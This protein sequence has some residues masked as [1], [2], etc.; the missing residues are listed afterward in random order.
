MQFSEKDQE[1]INL[2]LDELDDKQKYSK[3]LDKEK[4]VFL[5]FYSDYKNNSLTTDGRKFLKAT[6]K[7]FRLQQ[8]SAK[9]KLRQQSVITKQKIAER[10]ALANQKY[11]L[12]GACMASS[13]YSDYP[14]FF[15]LVQAMMGMF[16]EKKLEKLGIENTKRGYSIFNQEYFYSLELGQNKIVDGKVN[17]R[18][19]ITWADK[20]LPPDKHDFYYY[21]IKR[22]NE[23]T[24]T[25][26]YI[27]LTELLGK[28]IFN[29]LSQDYAENST[30]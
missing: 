16:D 7:N 4:Y 3:Y 19:L 6:I 17:G 27:F 23:V 20:K 29:V 18:I 5:S 24:V 1:T 2:I 28:M 10:K 9:E 26:G 13:Q 25:F 12:G 22:L 11:I 30:E 14:Y 21:S 8:K 15:E